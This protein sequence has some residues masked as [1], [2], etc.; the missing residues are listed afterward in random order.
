MG[1]R[2]ICVDSRYYYRAENRI[3]IRF[4]ANQ[5]AILTGN[6]LP[7]DGALRSC[8]TIIASQV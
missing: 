1:N 5:T 4:A 7:V 3:P 2:I 8:I 6:Q